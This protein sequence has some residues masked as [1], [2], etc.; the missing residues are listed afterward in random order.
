MVITMKFVRRISVFFIYPM[1]M[2]IF[3][4]ASGTVI[5][6]FFYP[7]EQYQEIKEIE[8][9]KEEEAV[10]ETVF[11]KE[12]VITADTSYIVI[13]YDMHSKKA[14]EKKEE[15]PD[16]YIGYDRSKLEEALIEYDKS[17]SLTDLEKGYLGIELLSFSPEKVI[18]Q[19]N[20]EK[21]EKGFYLLNENHKVMVYDKTLQYLYLDTGIRTED[22]PDS[23]QQEV[24]HMKYIANENEL[25]HFLESYSS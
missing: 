4:F 9:K 11:A 25:Y 13:S 7:G 1:T 16:S 6:D 20:Y 15:T 18:V 8:Q 5:Q 10:V 24:L 12:P 17:P 23:L 14:E 21:Q 3:G 2:F 22:L 19:K